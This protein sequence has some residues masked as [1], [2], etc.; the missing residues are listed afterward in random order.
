MPSSAPSG[1]P[2]HDPL[3]DALVAR[4]RAGEGEALEAL[5]RRHQGWIYN[6]A[7][8]MLQAREDAEDATQEILVKL[9]TRLGN[10]RGESAFRTWV[11]RIATNH[12]LDRQ[13]SCPEQAVHGFECYG[14]YLENAP[15][16]DLPPTIG[17]VQE[18]DLLVAEAKQACTLGMLLCLDRE[19]RLVF[20]LGEVFE[21]GDALGAAV[22]ELT[23]ANFRQ[24]LARARRQLYGFVAG[25]CGL[26]DPRNPCR[27]ER[28]TAAFIRD[29]IVDPQR[30]VFAAPALSRLREG[31]PERARRMEDLAHAAARSLYRDTPSFDAPDAA[32]KLRQIIA[33]PSWRATLEFPPDPGA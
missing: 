19:Q 32:A 3:D 12:V 11:W 2:S 10:F 28:K 1:R 18:R 30:L 16:E 33:S 27:C 14:Q 26:A 31:L 29:G 22:M 6:L 24:R 15:D 23:R 9:A 25:R 20:L 5:L 17:S 7:L 21:V 8:R 4:A 13:R